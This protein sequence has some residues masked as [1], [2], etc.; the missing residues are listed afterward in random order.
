MIGP[1]FVER[2]PFMRIAALA[3]DRLSLPLAG[4]IPALATLAFGFVVLYAVGFS[5]MP[6]VHNATHDTRHATGF[7]CH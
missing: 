1:A 3:P 5:T 2:K 6:A 7:P 4:R